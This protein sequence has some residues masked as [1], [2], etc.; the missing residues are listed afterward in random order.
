MRYQHLVTA[1][2]C[3][4]ILTPAV[5]S[6]QPKVEVSGIV[7]WTLSDGVEG[8]QVL[9]LD[10]NLYDALDVKDAFSWGFGVGFNATEQYEFGFLF[11]RQM[12]T[13]RAEG[14]NTVD[15]GDMAVD[16]Y[17]PYVAFNMGDSDA[18]VRPFILIGAGVTTYASVPFTRGGVSRETSGDTQFSTTWGGGVKFFASPNVGLRVSAT[19]SPTYITTEPGGTWC[20]PYWGCYVVGDAK[21]ANQFHF[22]GGVT[23]RF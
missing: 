22:N 14:T 5:A 3:V 21:Y 9:A 12:S 10:G 18:K 4:V 16:T 20:D 13:L 7:G 2:L 19:W 6:A 8:N 1:L 11:N 23:F 17:H 15:I